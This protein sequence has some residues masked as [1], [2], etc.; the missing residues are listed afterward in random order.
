MSLLLD[1][2]FSSVVGTC[3]AAGLLV[4][5][6]AR[7]AQGP[8]IAGLVAPIVFLLAYY[9]T[10]GKIPGFPPVGATNKI[11]YIVLAATSAGLLFDLLMPSRLAEAGGRLAVLL[12]ASLLIAV[13]I[14]V[15]RFAAMDAPLLL[16]V[17]AL[18]LGGTLALWR[19]ATMDFAEP[20]ALNGLILLAVLP[21]V[22]API[23]LFGGSSTSV[24]LCLGLTAGLAMMALVNLFAPRPLGLTAVLGAGS[25]LVAVIDTITLITRRIDFLALTLF[26]AVLFAGRTGARLLLPKRLARPAVRAVA[27]GL[28]AAVT[29]V[30]ILVILFLRHESPF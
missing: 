20:T 5:V 27:T 14:G 9:S 28:I 24:G 3:L 26:L 21:G 17:V 13:W 12:M 18:I 25:G 11:F 29:V 2:P 8:W 16:T 7:L 10:Y 30:P 4:S 23:A 1:S 19:V 6:L 15:P 22:F